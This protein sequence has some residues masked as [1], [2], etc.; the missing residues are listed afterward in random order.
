MFQFLVAKNLRI[1]FNSEQSVTER[2]HCCNFRIEYRSTSF[3][4]RVHV[5]ANTTKLFTSR[6]YFLSL[7]RSSK[8]IL[9]DF[10]PIRSLERFPTLTKY[11]HNRFVP[12]QASLLRVVSCFHGSFFSFFFFFKY[13]CY[14]A[15]Y[16]T[17]QDACRWST[18]PQITVNKRVSS[19]IIP[20][21]TAV[22]NF[23]V[24]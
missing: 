20:R 21:H 7:A 17:A 5:C 12:Y 1:K 18:W 19:R 22:Y 10:V 24:R 11:F 16:W 13:L 9:E 6:H 14:G 2:N 8:T 3:V 15:C 23:I 4:R